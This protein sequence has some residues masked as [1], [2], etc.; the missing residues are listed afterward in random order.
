MRTI[1]AIAAMKPPFHAAFVFFVFINAIATFVLFAAS[2]AGEW[3]VI[4]G[5]CDGGNGGYCCSI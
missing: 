3:F 5:A 1:R 4:A 2:S